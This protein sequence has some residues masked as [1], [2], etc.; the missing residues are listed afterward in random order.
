MKAPSA[1]IPFLPAL[2]IPLLAAAAGW[3][4]GKPLLFADT[5]TGLLAWNNFTTGGTWNTI[6]EP[7]P[8]NIADDIEYPVTWWSPGQY[9]PLGLLH[10]AGLPLGVAAL[11]ISLSCAWSATIGFTLLA[12]ALGAPATSLPWVAVAV[13]GSWHTLYVFGMFI[14][15]EALLPAVWPWIALAGWQ[16]RERGWALVLVLPPL[17]LAGAFAKHSFVIPGLSL[18][19]FLWLARIPKSRVNLYSVTRSAAPLVGAGLLFLLGHHFLFD[20]GPSPSDPGQLPPRALAAFGFSAFAPLLSATGAGSIAGRIFFKSGIPF[21]EGWAL[22]APV[23]VLF[24]PLPL[25]LF[26]WLIRQ[27]SPL[28]RFAGLAALTTA[29]LLCILIW[30]GGSISLE[31]RHYRPA[32]LLLLSVCAAACVHPRSRIATAARTLVIGT[33]LFGVGSSI[34]RHQSLRQ[35]THR[36]NEHLS[37]ADFPPPVLAKLRL[38]ASE[39]AGTDAIIFLP[40]VEIS[41]HLPF[42]RMIVTDAIDRD[43]AWINARPRHGLV[44]QITVLMPERFSADGRAKALIASFRDFSS[45]AWTCQ[46]IS[47]WE[48][49]QNVEAALPQSP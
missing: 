11:L 34:Q 25:A 14:G 19:T 26:V 22:I 7:D 43:I 1:F 31:D 42:C 21:E 33:V 27:S 4:W 47:G 9:V 3:F 36:G 6:R 46:T 8:A 41:A 29:G 49:W 39:A 35:H 18:L 13:A 16:L 45:E 5:G 40:S 38:I 15:G 48:F 24:S 32:G 28:K 30:R 10:S 20:T 23:L 17:F 44:S 12:R 37:L 2:L